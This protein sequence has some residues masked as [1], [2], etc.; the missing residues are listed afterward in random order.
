MVMWKASRSLR[1]TGTIYHKAAKVSREKGG[2]QEFYSTLKNLANVVWGEEAAEFTWL[3]L[4]GYT[5]QESAEDHGE[6]D[7]VDGPRPFLIVP[8]KRIMMSET[9]GTFEP[10]ENQTAQL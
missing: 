5:S 10:N 8:S 7:M 2:L 9:K 1:F 4:G 6:E 3:R